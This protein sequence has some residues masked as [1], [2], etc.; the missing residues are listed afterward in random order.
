L[1]CSDNRSDKRAVEKKLT[2]V[3]ENW[4]NLWGHSPA[5]YHKI[6]IDLSD[7]KPVIAYVDFANGNKIKVQKW[8]NDETWTDLGY[9]T[10]EE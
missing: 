1:N 10:D 3:G 5:G 7:N 4:S 8:S 6:A 9:V 2:G